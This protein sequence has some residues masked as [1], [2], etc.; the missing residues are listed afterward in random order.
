MW[1]Q[2]LPHIQSLLRQSYNYFQ[3]DDKED[4][5]GKKIQKLLQGSS[6]KLL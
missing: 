4:F 5:F 2:K 3:T 6:I 1:V